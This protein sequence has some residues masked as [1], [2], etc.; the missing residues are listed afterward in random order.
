MVSFGLRVLPASRLSKLAALTVVLALSLTAPS[1]TAA[2]RHRGPCFPAHSRTLI[3]TKRARVFRVPDR[4]SAVSFDTL[5]CAFTFK[6]ARGSPLGR[7]DG[8]FGP[9]EAYVFQPPALSLAGFLVGY[10]VDSCDAVSCITAV[11]V[12]NLR[13]GNTMLVRPA[14]VNGIPVKVGSLRIDVG[15][16]VAWIICP[17]PVY[18]NGAT[19]NIYG[20]RAPDCLRPGAQDK[21]LKSTGGGHF[22]NGNDANG[23][24]TFVGGNL[25]VLDRGRQIDPLSLRLRGERLSWI[26]GRHHR[27]ARL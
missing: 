3:Q 17:E 7:V 13:T 20:G 27:H 10:A 21:V 23:M 1:P 15:G 5:S 4:N 18:A 12:D 9:G 26:S 2:P 6:P 24:P 11:A 22:G 16:H 8:M 25:S 19:G 14:G